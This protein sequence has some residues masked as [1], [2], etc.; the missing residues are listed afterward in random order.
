MARV[1]IGSR[2][3]HDF[4]GTIGTVT[5]YRRDPQGYNYEVQWDDRGNKVDWYKRKVLILL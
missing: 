4:S 5:N 2:V 3:K 1:M